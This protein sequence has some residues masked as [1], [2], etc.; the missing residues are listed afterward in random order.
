MTMKSKRRHS[1]VTTKPEINDKLI[2]L[3]I[4]CGTNKQVGFIGVDRVELP[5]VDQ[6]VDLEVYP[7]PWEDGSVEEIYCSHY[8]EHT[9]DLIVFMDE[10]YRVLQVGGKMTVVAPYYTSMRAWQD[11]TH[12]RAIS[13][14]TF[15][16]FNKG[17]RTANGLE[18]YGI[19]S[20]FDFAYGYVFSPL[21]QNRSEEARSFALLH[22]IN[23]ALDIQ[24]TLIKREQEIKEVS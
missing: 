21:W 10:C 23:V 2:K 19:K 4:G 7:W 24:V 6:I 20:D 9:T 14:A 8:I 3:D 18:H 1:R 17:W 12:K 11:P 15:L 5:G 22:Y 16:Y 13:E